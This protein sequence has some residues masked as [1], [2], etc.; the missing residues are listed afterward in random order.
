MTFPSAGQIPSMSAMM[1]M[2]QP[3]P[4][5][6]KELNLS[7]E[8]RARW[9]DE[10]ELPEHAPVN[11]AYAFLLMGGKGYAV[12][13]GEAARWGTIE[14]AVDGTDAEA[15][16]R[17]AAMERSGATVKFIEM[18][19]FFECRATSH[20]PDFKAGDITIRPLYLAVAKRVDDV[21]EGGGYVRRR[22]PLNEYLKAMRDRYPEITE[23]V[24]LTCERYV[25]LQAKGNG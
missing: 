13:R 7:D 25:A 6:K 8:W 24:G 22:L 9:I 19:G 1:N 15:F 16:V 20:N 12:R 2:Y 17:R 5:F 11:Y 10:H 14:G 4:A 3:R 18:M 21:P 23:Y